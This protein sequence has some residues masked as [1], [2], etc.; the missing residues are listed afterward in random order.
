MNAEPTMSEPA[1]PRPVGA[2]RTV[3]AAGRFVEP[4][5]F[6]ADWIDDIRGCP[7]LAWRMFLRGFNQQYRHS[8]LGV[9]LAFAPVLLT[10]LVIALGR[11]AQI[12][13][14]DI[15]G[16]HSAFFAAFGIL[17]VQAFVEGIGA[18][19]RIFTVNAAFLKRQVVPIEAPL[20]AAVFDLAF[21]DL[22][23][24][25]VIGVLMATFAVPPS[26]WLPLA[27]WAIFGISLAGGAIGLVSAP[28]SSLTTDLQVFT[29]A[30]MILVITTTP[31]F[32]VPAPESAL[33]RVQAAN[34]LTWAF[35][36]VRAAAYGAPGSL[37][38]AACLLPV[39]FAA[40]LVGGFAC[41]VAKPHLL[42]RMTGQGG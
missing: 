17:L 11:R 23:R 12:V 39:G 42:E 14:S 9:I 15:G 36:A 34:P 31:V 25:A 18:T 16:V 35:D 26:P 6:L 10:A 33:G 24:L 27:A 2:A 38:L 5:R 4:R 30:L 19:Q 13:A 41:R 21:R 22:V 1:A 8:V 32:L 40:F 28:F 7:R 29:R 37:A 3:T 20:V